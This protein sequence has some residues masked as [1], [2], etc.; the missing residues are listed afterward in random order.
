MKY[1]YNNHKSIPAEIF[2]VSL[3]VNNSSFSKIFSIYSLF[4]SFMSNFLFLSSLWYFTHRLFLF[5]NWYWPSS[6]PGSGI[7]AGENFI[8]SAACYLKRKY[9][10]CLKWSRYWY[11]SVVSPS[12][13]LPAVISHL[14][15]FRLLL[16]HTTCY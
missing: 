15:G 12:L 3:Y 16:S 9:I 5:F 13:P 10:F 11:C 6:A 2:N 1:K 4:Y 7:S 8:W 14:L